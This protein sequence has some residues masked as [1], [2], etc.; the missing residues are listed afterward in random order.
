M[1][2][3]LSLCALLLV[4]A[5]MLSAADKPAPAA[6]TPAVERLKTEQWCATHDL[7]KDVCATC[8]KKLIPALKKANDWCAEHAVAESVCV[9]CDPT[10]KARL[11]AMRPIDTP[12]AVK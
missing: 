2:R 8:D 4:S 6:E 12:K 11:D 9:L 7:P 1:I 3:H 10:A 5:G